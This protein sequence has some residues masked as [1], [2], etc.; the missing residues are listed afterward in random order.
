MSSL[1]Q[2]AIDAAMHQVLAADGRRVTVRRGN[3]SVA[4]TAAVSKSEYTSQAATGLVLQIETRDYLLLAADY[5]PDAAPSLPAA[6][7]LFREQI[8]GQATTWEVA[9]P[10]PGQQH[11][12]PIDPDGRWLR[13]HTHQ[14]H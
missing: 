1:Q 5:L 6:G 13:V 9:S 14:L 8:N 12:R 4:L 10:G 3:L 2:I 7:D 11:Y